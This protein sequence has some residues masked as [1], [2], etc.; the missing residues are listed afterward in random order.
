MPDLSIFSLFFH[1]AHQITFNY[2]NGLALSCLPGLGTLL[3]FLEILVT[4]ST[5]ISPQYL[6]FAQSVIATM[7]PGE[8]AEAGRAYQSRLPGERWRGWTLSKP[9]SA[10]LL[11]GPP[12]FHHSTQKHLNPPVPGQSVLGVLLGVLPCDRLWHLTYYTAIFRNVFVHIFP[13]CDE[14]HIFF[15]LFSSTDVMYHGHPCLF[16]EW[17]CKCWVCIFLL[18]L[19]FSWFPLKSIIPLSCMFYPMKNPKTI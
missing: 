17:M 10:G 3:F 19:W 1:Q 16:V 8:K 13:P 6:L 15:I 4:L 2:L 7:L 11:K 12:S 5:W 18:C 9:P 14:I